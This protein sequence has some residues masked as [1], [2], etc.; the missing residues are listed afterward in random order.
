M[1]QLEKMHGFSMNYVHDITHHLCCFSCGLHPTSVSCV[2]RYKS[3]EVYSCIQTKTHIKIIHILLKNIWI[4][5]DGDLKSVLK[6]V[7]KKNP[8]YQKNLGDELNFI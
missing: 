7:M 4:F 2:M 8:D 1:W 6:T 3:L 5:P